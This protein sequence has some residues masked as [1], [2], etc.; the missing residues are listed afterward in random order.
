MFLIMARPEL[1]DARPGWGSG[2]VN[3]TTI[4]LEP[5]AASASAELLLE[6]PGGSALPDEL[7]RRIADKAEGNPLFLEEILRMLIDEGRLAATVSGWRVDP[8]IS[9]VP[10]PGSIAALLAARLDRLALGERQVAERASVVGRIFERNAVVELSPLP[11]RPEV[12]SRLLSLVRKELVRPEAEPGMAGDDAYR[13]RHLLIRDAVYEAMPKGDRASLHVAFAAWLERVTG[14]RIGEYAEVVAHHLERAYHYRE[15]LG[16]IG[17]EE[18][19]RQ[20]SS[21]LASAARRAQM[22]GDLPAAMALRRQAL[23]LPME[24]NHRVDMLV[25][26]A[27]SHGDVGDFQDATKLLDEA[28]RLVAGLD[29]TPLRMRVVVGRGFDRLHRGEHAATDDI[30]EDA[31][32]AA[33][34]LE[35]AGDAV[36]VARAHELSALAAY[37]GGDIMAAREGWRAAAEWARR[38][39]DRGEAARILPA[40]PATAMYG[41]STSAEAIDY[42]RHLAEE[43]PDAPMLHPRLLAIMALQHAWRGELEIAL[44]LREKSRALLDELGLPWLTGEIH[45]DYADVDLMRGAFQDAEREGRLAHAITSGVRWPNAWEA[46]LTVLYALHAQHRDQEARDWLRMLGEMPGTDTPSGRANLPLW[47]ALL[48]AVE[49]NLAEARAALDAARPL[50]RD[51]AEKAAL[52]ELRAQTLALLGDRDAAL[53]DYREAAS[54]YD[55]K[56][57]FQLSATVRLRIE[58]LRGSG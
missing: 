37:F 29:D 46:G 19:G 30:G 10:V 32:R 53:E 24:A 28:E 52:L 13:F 16:E 1:L 12:M 18:L 6:L 23:A 20:A 40:L 36:G 9:T 44:D 17:I 21:S 38:S 39:G 49:G 51:P 41:W 31:R 58:Q 22:R 42:C 5:L 45:W 26:Q 27:R 7:R 33:E 50:D 56:E 43:Y 15:Q 2:K 4:P 11:E 47:S 55:R 14:D 8:E 34:L 57:Y 25:Q 35:A 48:H 3:A 54:I